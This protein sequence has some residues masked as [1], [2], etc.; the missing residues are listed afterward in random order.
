M[1]NLITTDNITEQPVSLVHIITGV[2][3]FISHYI[4][5]HINIPGSSLFGKKKCV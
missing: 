1:E 5:Q 2:T 4:I 3:L